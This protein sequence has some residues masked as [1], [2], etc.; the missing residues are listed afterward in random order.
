MSENNIE[1]H[2]VIELVESYVQSELRDFEQYENRAPFDASGVYSLHQLARDA[3]ALGV[4]DGTRQER[5]RQA[6]Q[7]QRDRDARKALPAGVCAICGGRPSE[8]PPRWTHQDDGVHHNPCKE[9]ADQ[10]DAKK[11]DRP[12]SEPTDV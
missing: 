6:R 2:Q 4:G 7:A 8:E 1:P 11:R 9:C 10:L 5:Y 3:Y 12:E